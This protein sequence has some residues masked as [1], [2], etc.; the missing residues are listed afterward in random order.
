LP[1]SG[2]RHAGRRDN[3]S[4][5]ELA[6]AEIEAMIG[7]VAADGPDAIAVICTNMDAT[8][9]GPRLE[10]SLGIPVLDSIAC[11][12]WGALT[13]CVSTRPAAP[14]RSAVPVLASD[15]IP[16]NAGDHVDAGASVEVDVSSLRVS[17]IAGGLQ[18][19]SCMDYAARTVSRNSDTS[20][21][22]LCALSASLLA[23][24]ST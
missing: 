10:A 12:L 20:W 22:R 19:P 23:E 14:R 24:A 8:R 5:A 18:T 15:V 6:P 4:F 17:A 9:L 2:E 3:F 1:A 13:L 7:A 16:A 11:A 21:L